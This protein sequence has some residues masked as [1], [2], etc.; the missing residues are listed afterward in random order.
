M[1]LIEQKKIP[2]DYLILLMLWDF[3][4]DKQGE[5]ERERENKK[6]LSWAVLVMITRDLKI[7]FILF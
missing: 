7:S 6:W 3:R 1:S 4:F 5:R 2:V